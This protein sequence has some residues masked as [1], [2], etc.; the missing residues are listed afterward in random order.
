MM[1][2]D[3]IELDP[4]LPKMDVASDIAFLVMDL[5][6]RGRPDLAAHVA[7]SWM[8]SANDHAVAGVLQLYGA[9][10]A[11]VRAGVAAI[12]G[13]QH[14]NATVDC[15]ET[16]CDLRLAELATTVL[17]VGMSDVIDAAYLRRW[18]RQIMAETG[19]STGM[20]LVWL[21]CDVRVREAMAHVAARWADSGDASDASAE[22]VRSQAAFQEPII[23]AELGDRCRLF[24]LS[25]Q[26]ITSC[27][28]AGPLGD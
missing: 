5:Q 14:G 12:R 25:W 2:F 24:R 23:S 9:S 10:R 6:A 21:E 7:S 20:P 16:D 15:L 13:G 18:Q 3:A 19:R 26:D 22:V 11:V 8:E 27:D 4:A 28:L 1:A 17:S